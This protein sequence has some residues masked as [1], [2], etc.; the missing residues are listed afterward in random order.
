MSM[1]GAPA[2]GPSPGSVDH[3]NLL[4][5]LGT[6]R[7]LTRVWV[8]L[9]VLVGVLNLLAILFSILTF[10]FPGGGIGGLVYAAIWVGVDLLLLD[11]LN[12]WSALLAEGHYQALKEPFLL[13]GIL[14]LLFGVIPG[15]LLLWLYLK[16]LPW[17][18]HPGPL[19]PGVAPPA[20]TV[21]PPGALHPAPVGGPSAE[22]PKS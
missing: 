17:P 19:G 21:I 5:L 10:R 20:G 7:T 22:S 12:G 13:W 16:V 14:G 3:A 4:S 15:V 18:D 8:L 6:T 2:Q 11:R 9:G 1:M